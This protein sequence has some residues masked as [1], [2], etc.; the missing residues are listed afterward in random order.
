MSIDTIAAVAH[1]D[2]SNVRITRLSRRRTQQ[3]DLKESVTVVYNVATFDNR[4]EK[5]I[6]SLSNNLYILMEFVGYF[7][8][9]VLAQLDLPDYERSKLETA[10]SILNVRGV[11]WLGTEKEVVLTQAPTFDG[12][13][14]PTKSRTVPPTSNKSNDIK[15]LFGVLLPLGFLILIGVAVYDISRGGSCFGFVRNSTVSSEPAVSSDATSSSRDAPVPLRQMEAAL[16]FARNP[17]VSS[18]P[19]ASSD[20]TFSSQD[21]PVPLR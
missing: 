16:G 17:T 2:R 12:A 1:T 13:A 5:A 8:A 15:I 7:K 19:A 11:K 18:K 3:T 21:A 10:L 4:A 20:A 6:Q 9:R 14:S